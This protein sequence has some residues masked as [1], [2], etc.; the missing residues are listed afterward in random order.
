MPRRPKTICRKNGCYSL[1]NS[2]GYCDIHQDESSPFKSLDSKKTV[3]TKKFY[4]SWKWTKTSR[5]HRIK[6]PLCEQ[7]QTDGK[8]HAAEMVHHEPPLE[9][10]L[11]KGLNPLSEKYLHSLCNSCHLGELRD[12]RIATRY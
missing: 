4:S 12:K 8:T 11:K 5:Q 7:C 2:P 1:I 6:Y 10:L 9:V 3:E